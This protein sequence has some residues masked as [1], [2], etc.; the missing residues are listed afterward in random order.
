MELPDGG[1]ELY[2]VR[3]RPDIE[4]KV[5]Y[6]IGKFYKCELWKV[7]FDV[8]LYSFESLWCYA[9]D[10]GFGRVEEKVACMLDYDKNGHGDAECGEEVAR[11]DAHIIAEGADDS[12]VW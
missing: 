3:V 2:V 7:V 5:K 6:S 9:K 10:L 12:I 4:A 8:V 11:R 1:C